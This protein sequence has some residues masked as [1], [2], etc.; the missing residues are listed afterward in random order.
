MVQATQG[1]TVA[2]LKA[3]PASIVFKGV[4]LG[5]TQDGQEIS[6][7][8][9]W[10]DIIV[11]QFGETPIDA[12]LTAQIVT[13]TTILSEFTL[14]NLQKVLGGAVKVV[15]GAKEKVTVG[16]SAG[17]RARSDAGV[18]TL[19]PIVNAVADVTEDVTFHKA[20]VNDAVAFAMVHNGVRS[21]TVVWRCL[22]DETKTEGNHLFTIGDTSASA[23]TTPLSVSSVSPVDGATGVAVGD[24]VVITLDD[25]DLLESTM[26]ANT[27]FL[28]KDSD[29]S[30]V[31]AALSWNSGSSEITLNPNSDLSASS[32]YRLVVTGIED[33]NGNTLA[34]PFSSNFQTA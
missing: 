3:G 7:E 19:H 28:I 2:N 4:T 16:R 10:A 27:V 15:D 13:C 17:Y 20:Y 29:D 6:D 14:D 23:D 30:I 25:D 26:N 22:I 5:F 21:Y 31:A 33:V 34:T 32:D 18:L 9:T 11:D 1:G 8:P 12:L 24:N